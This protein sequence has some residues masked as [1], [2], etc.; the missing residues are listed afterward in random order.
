MKT[1]VFLFCFF[2]VS[3]PLVCGSASEK[4]RWLAYVLLC[5]WG[6][7]EWFFFSWSIFDL[8]AIGKERIHMADGEWIK[9]MPFKAKSTDRVDGTLRVAIN[10]Q[11]KL[12]PD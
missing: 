7:R 10:G 1:I 9:R 5:G 8:F 6:K 4:T 11:S 12:S 3:I 2:F